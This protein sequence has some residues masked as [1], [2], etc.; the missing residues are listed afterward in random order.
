MCLYVA[1]EE[2][3]LFWYKLRNVRHND[4]WSAIQGVY[5]DRQS[6][7]GG[8]KQICLQRCEYGHDRGSDHMSFAAFGQTL[9]QLRRQNR[10]VQGQ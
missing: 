8:K 3:S 4:E 10:P 6:C 9:L 5:G 2:Y 1:E 7:T